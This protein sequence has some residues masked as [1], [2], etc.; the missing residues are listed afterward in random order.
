MLK[1]QERP[2]ENKFSMAFNVSKSPKNMILVRA[3]AKEGFLDW[4]KK[5]KDSSVI[6]NINSGEMSHKVLEGY[7]N[8]FDE[9]RDDENTPID[10]FREQKIIVSQKTKITKLKNQ[11]ANQTQKAKDVKKQNKLLQ[12]IQSQLYAE[13]EVQALINKSKQHLEDEISNLI[14]E[15]NGLLKDNQS[16]KAKITNLNRSNQN[17]R[18]Q[19]IES[20]R[21]S[22]RL[23]DKNQELEN[24][25]QEL[26]DENK[27]LQQ[28]LDQAKTEFQIP[29]ELKNT[30]I[31]DALTMYIEQSRQI[32][33][34]KQRNEHL[35]HS[36]SKLKN[37]ATNSAKNVS[38]PQT[39]VK[40]SR[41]NAKKSTAKSPPAENNFLNKMRQEYTEA[42]LAM[43][44]D[45]KVTVYCGVPGA[46][47]RNLKTLNVDVEIVVVSEGRLR[48]V[49]SKARSNRPFVFYDGLHSHAIDNILNNN[50]IN[51]YRIKDGDSSENIVAKMIEILRAG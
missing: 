27:D 32:K 17:Y 26:K 30:P 40:N 5:N 31:D 6:E 44:Q 14:A 46:I 2:R 19:L 36:N 15:K 13:E 29:E 9:W 33:E 22:E 51:A 49:Q 3:Q 48:I 37:K 21:Y 24:E 1:V 28:K 41:P 34:L 39:R 12:K 16:Y 25:K 38:R 47:R 43:L 20:Q 8:E 42:E 18:N 45:Q 50:N 23:E 10:D 7:F 4:T 11:L 35:V